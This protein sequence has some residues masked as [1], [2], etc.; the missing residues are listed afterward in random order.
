MNDDDIAA[1][2]ELLIVGGQKPLKP[3]PVPTELEQKRQMMRQ[4]ERLHQVRTIPLFIGFLTV[5]SKDILS[6]SKVL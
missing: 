4:R 1:H 5:M 2:K 3:A 6:A